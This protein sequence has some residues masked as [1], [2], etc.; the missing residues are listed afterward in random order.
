MRGILVFE[1]GVNKERVDF[2]AS[3]ILFKILGTAQAMRVLNM[4]V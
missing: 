3:C 4:N 2:D 1:N